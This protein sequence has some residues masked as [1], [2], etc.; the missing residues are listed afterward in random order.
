VGADGYFK[1]ISRR[2]LDILLAKPV[3]VEWFILAEPR[4]GSDLPE[5]V[6]LRKRYPAEMACVDNTHL[7]TLQ[8]EWREPSFDVEKEWQ[9]LNCMVTGSAEGNGGESPL[10]DAICGGTELGYELGY[11][12]PRYLCP[13]EVQAVSGALS[14]AS[15]LELC[16]HLRR[17]SERWRK[18]DCALWQE[19][20]EGLCDYYRKA[21]EQGKGM[22][23]YL[24]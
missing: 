5:L 18:E 7:A 16:E 10:R 23:L 6:S 19:D 12:R 22:L 3:L 8:E 21:A 24:I 2:G 4:F 15:G 1:S 9:G 14:A 17:L 20:Y 11:G 13:S